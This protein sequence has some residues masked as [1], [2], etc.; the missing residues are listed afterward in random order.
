MPTSFKQLLAR[1][2]WKYI[3]FYAGVPTHFIHP[4]YPTI[5]S[6]EEMIDQLNKQIYATTTK[7]NSTGSTH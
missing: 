4:N 7:E 5:Y 6:L 3:P 2:G 1:Y